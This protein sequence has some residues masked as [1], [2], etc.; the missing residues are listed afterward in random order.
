VRV[1]TEDRGLVTLSTPLVVALLA[2]ALDTADAQAATCAEH[3][4]DASAQ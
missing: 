1:F 4:N 2:S 3:P